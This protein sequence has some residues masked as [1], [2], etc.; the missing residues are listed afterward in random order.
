MWG[1]TVYK[2]LVRRSQLQVIGIEADPDKVARARRRLAA[3]GVYGSRVTVLHATTLS[4]L[5]K[6]VST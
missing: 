4:P 2:E 1:D 6:A 3:A 5:P